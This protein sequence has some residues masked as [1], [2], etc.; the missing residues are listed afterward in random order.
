MGLDRQQERGKYN[1]KKGGLEGEQEW[2]VGGEECSSSSS[3]QEHQMPFWLKGALFIL[4]L[5]R[6]HRIPAPHQ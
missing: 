5:V 4:H 6:A 3:S 1:G 2:G